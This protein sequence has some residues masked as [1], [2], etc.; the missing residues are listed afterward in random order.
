MRVWPHS[1]ILQD[2]EK[3]MSNYSKHCL[4]HCCLWHG[5]LGW[6]QQRLFL[7]ELQP[8]PQSLSYISASCLNSLFQLTQTISPFL[9]MCWYWENFK[10]EGEFLKS[11]TQRPLESCLVW[12]KADVWGQRRHCYWD[13]DIFQNTPRPSP[14]IL[15]T[16]FIFPTNICLQSWLPIPGSFKQIMT[17]LFNKLIWTW[18]LIPKVAPCAWNL[19]ILNHLKVSNE[20]IKY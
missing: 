20:I 2:S 10:Y 11:Y 6:L 14:T 1:T 15:P 17:R 16:N 13:T 8:W 3:W 9:W 12:P 5:V 7:P 18:I 4:S 19:F